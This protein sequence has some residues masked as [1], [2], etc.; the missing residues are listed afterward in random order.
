MGAALPLEHRVGALAL[1]REDDLL[2]AAGLVRARGEHLR[3]EAAPL[4]VASQHA[5][6]V[7]RPERRLV[8]ADALADLDQHVLAVGRVGLDQ[9]ELQILLEAG[10][11]LLEL[12]DELAQVAVSAGVVEVGASLA[13][14]LCEPVRALE[15]LQAPADLGRLAVIVVDGRVG[16]TLLRLAVGALD[17][18]DELFDGGH[19]SKGTALLSGHLTPIAKP[20]CYSRDAIRML[21]LPRRGGA[22]A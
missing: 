6:D 11:P 14:L 5:V 15:L 3:L 20:L 19:E 21:A 16:H 22:R 1:D 17:F 12:R 9:R 18:V 7:A 10:D 8:A 2:E 4:R 13:P